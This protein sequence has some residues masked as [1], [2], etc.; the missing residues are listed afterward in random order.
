MSKAHYPIALQ[1][2]L[3]F[4]VETMPLVAF[5]NFVNFFSKSKKEYK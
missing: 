3:I 1:P 5:I 2:Q 4:M